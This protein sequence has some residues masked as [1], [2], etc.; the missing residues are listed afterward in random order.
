M[1]FV[2]RFP[3]I[4]GIDAGDSDESWHACSMRKHVIFLVERTSRFQEFKFVFSLEISHLLSN[5]SVSL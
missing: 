2:W 3:G 4:F 1:N 5:V